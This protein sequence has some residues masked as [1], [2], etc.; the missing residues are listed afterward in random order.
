MARQQFYLEGRLPEFLVEAT[1][2][3]RRHLEAS[4]ALREGKAV[5]AAELL[6]QGEEQRSPLPGTCDGT[7]FDDCRDLDDL[8]GPV[9]EVITSS[10]KY[11]WVP[12]EHVE[13]IEFSPPE[14]AMDLIWR[15]AQ[16][17]VV[18]GPEGGVYVPV[19][20]PGSGEAGDSQ[21]KLGRGTDWQ[22]GND[23][24]VRGIGQRMLLL[25]DEAKPIMQLRRLEFRS[26]A[27]A[28]ADLQ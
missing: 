22:G 24:P 12:L 5:E 10:G 9:L 17:T 7:P 11:Y 18:G 1:P 6:A 28:D 14:R 23:A 25:G 13:S 20:Y 26:A 16:V 3:I 19:L 8:I 4:I 27:R 2:A 21:L 15:T